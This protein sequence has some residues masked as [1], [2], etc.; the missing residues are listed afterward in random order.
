MSIGPNYE[1]DGGSW[2]CGRCG[3]PLEQ[4]KVQVFY[5]NSAFDVAAALSARRLTMCP[6]HW[7]R[8]RCWK[9]KPCW[10]TSEPALHPAGIQAHRGRTL[11]AGGTEI[12]DR[13]L[14]LGRRW[15]DAGAEGRILDVGC[16]P[17][18]SVRHLRQ[19][20]R[21]VW[22]LDTVLRPQVADGSSA[23]DR[24][25][26]VSGGRCLRWPAPGGTVCWI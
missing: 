2:T 14:A 13:L 26:A 6:S 25:T 21:Q 18:G 20:G 24:G 8:A 19:Q 23:C 16:G 22:G 5:L 12:T 3:C 7:P 4:G 10:K 15:H 1:P 11:A 9:W 17:G